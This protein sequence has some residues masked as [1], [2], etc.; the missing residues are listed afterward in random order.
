LG[1]G[2]RQ[3]AAIQG[4]LLNQVA[5]FCSRPDQYVWMYVGRRDVLVPFDCG[6]V[7]S[8]TGQE[9]VTPAF[10]SG[11]GLRVE[12]HHLWIVEGTLHC[13]ESNVLTRRRFYLEDGSWRILLGEGYDI[14]ETLVT[15]YL[16][17][18][19]GAG[20]ISDRGCWYSTA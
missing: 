19:Y 10:P 16:L 18:M 20:E 9:L 12:L 4:I 5:S 7:H 1:S 13:G 14:T 6:P 17:H 11:D 8:G 15:C 3:G 2:D